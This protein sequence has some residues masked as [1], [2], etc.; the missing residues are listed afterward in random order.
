MTVTGHEPMTAV[1][2]VHAQHW[3]R[4]LDHHVEETIRAL[5]PAHGMT[6]VTKQQF[7]ASCDALIKAL[8]N[9]R[10]RFGTGP[11]GEPE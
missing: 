2:R 8:R 10:R 4:G 5:S 9:I 1:E 3:L 6:V 11:G 7:D